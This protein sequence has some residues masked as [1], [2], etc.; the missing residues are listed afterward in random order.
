MI[1]MRNQGH[2]LQE[3]GDEF[4]ISR[5]YARQLLNRETAITTTKARR[6]TKERGQAELKIQIAD[7]VVAMYHETPNVQ[8]IAR[9]NGWPLQVVEDIVAENYPVADRR[10][11]QGRQV[12]QG[13]RQISN[14]DLAAHVRRAAARHPLVPLRLKEYEAYAKEHG[15]PG[16]QTVSRRFGG[17]DHSWTEALVEIGGIAH[18]ARARAPRSAPRFGP[19]EAVMAVATVA[20]VIGHLPTV[21]EYERERDLI[22]RTGVPSVATIRNRTDGWANALGL[23]QALLDEMGVD[24][25]E[26]N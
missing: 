23:A 26:R 21:A 22:G 25:H 11:L 9:Q 14:E 1:Q 6:R 19:R 15:V 10:K 2:T 20:V 4:G 17:S 13:S 5:E 3:I 8:T 18:S 7:E 16:P 24:L 12:S